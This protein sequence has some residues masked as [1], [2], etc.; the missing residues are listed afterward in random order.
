MP[1]FLNSWIPIGILT[2]TKTYRISTCSTHYI[3]DTSRFH[4]AW[5]ISI[6]NAAIAANNNSWW[7]RL[8]LFEGF[9]RKKRGCFFKKSDVISMMLNM[10]PIDNYLTHR[11]QLIYKNNKNNAGRLILST[12]LIVIFLKFSKPITLW[13][14][15]APCHTFFKLC[16]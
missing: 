12:F 6:T 13:S 2:I 10:H 8:R 3:I 9:N 15:I 14:C 5:R 1:P 7:S 4:V 11:H 16:I